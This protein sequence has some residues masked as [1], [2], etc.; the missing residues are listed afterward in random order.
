MDEPFAYISTEMEGYV[1]NILVVYDIA[2]PARPA[3][4]SRW[5]MPGQHIAGGE[6]PHWTGQRNRLHHA[7][8]FGDELWASVWYAGLR[9]HRRLRHHRPADDGRLRL[10]PAV[11]RADPHHRP[12]P[13][14]LAGRQV[15][16]AVD[17]EH[18]HTHGQLHG[19]LWFFDVEDRADIKPIGM[20]HLSE[21]DSPFARPQP[22]SARISSRNE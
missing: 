13:G 12:G 5:W 14:P 18:D 17:E 8:R 2:D 16:V 7:L 4:V 11:P 19:G 22:A 3:E 10:P 20:F 6:T 15:A 21:L 1:G 9:V